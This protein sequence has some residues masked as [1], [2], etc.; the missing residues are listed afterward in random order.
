MDEKKTVASI[1]VAPTSFPGLFPLKL[2]KGK[3]LETRLSPAPSQGKGSGRDSQRDFE[4]KH[5]RVS[6][7]SKARSASQSFVFKDITSTLPFIL[8]SEV[9]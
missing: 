5:S 3:A 8:S 9:C 4:A 6:A 7:G 1:E 2:G